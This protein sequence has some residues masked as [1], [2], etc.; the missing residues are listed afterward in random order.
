MSKMLIFICILVFYVLVLISVFNVYNQF[1]CREYHL[2]KYEQKN[3][4]N[5]ITQENFPFFYQQNTNMLTCKS[6]QNLLSNQKF[7]SEENHFDPYISEIIKHFQCQKYDS[8][9]IK[10]TAKNS[11][12]SSEDTSKCNKVLYKCL[13]FFGTEEFRKRRAGKYLWK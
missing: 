2:S 10:E 8:N 9:N 12:M 13:S 1:R 3:L 11:I 6:F 7:F 4:K 5:I